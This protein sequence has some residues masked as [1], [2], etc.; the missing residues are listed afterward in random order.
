MGPRAMQY[1]LNLSDDEIDSF[2]AVRP[3]PVDLA[4][5]DVL[6]GG[7]L[8]SAALSKV[9]VSDIQTRDVLRLLMAS[10]Q[11]HAISNLDADAS[12]LKGLYSK[13]QWSESRA[14]AICLTGLQGVGKTELLNA[15]GRIFANQSSTFSVAGHKNIDLVPLWKMTLS[16]GDG[17]NELLRKFIDASWAED[18]T[19]VEAKTSKNWSISK[20]LTLAQRR[21]WMSATCL[22]IADEFQWIAASSAANARAASVL[23]KLHG[24]GP[25][26]VYCANFSLVHKLKLRPPE[27]LDRL[28]CR[29]LTIKPFTSDSPEFTAY[30]DALQ[31]VESGTFEIDLQRDQEQI[32]LYTYGI[33]RKVV[34]LFV[35]AY[36]ISHLKGRSGKVGAQEL[37]L[38]YRSEFYTMHR[39]QVEILFRQQVTGKMEKKD[40]WCPFGAMD[41][42][43]SNV[44]EAE[45]IVQAFERRTED[46]LLHAALTPSESAAADAINPSATKYSSTAKVVRFRRTKVTKES[47]LEGAA[48]LDKL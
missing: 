42:E 20:I 23:L 36:K 48:A 12:F 31:Q 15:L 13:H 26:L 39:E 10:A 4:G 43:R 45:K 21:S 19:N 35:A 32:H 5:V 40:L 8:L 16:K 18:L 27:E 24:I 44:K 6:V 7:E 29:P 41:P 37:L 17:L 1:S 9:V 11:A 33:R 3:K 34:D 47:L 28:M 14:P 38:A 22:A 46:A 25:L 30:L 2:V